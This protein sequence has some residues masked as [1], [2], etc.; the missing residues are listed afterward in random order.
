MIKEIKF[1]LF[2]LTI[3]IFIFLILKYY[4]SDDYKKIFFIN[5]ADYIKNS[6]VQK[7]PILKNDTS[8]IIEYLNYNNENNR[9]N[10]SFYELIN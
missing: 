5:K 4:F 7:L 6:K 1:F 9:K 8:D 2:F 3:L 10:R